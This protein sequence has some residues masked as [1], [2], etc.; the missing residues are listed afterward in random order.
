[1]KIDKLVF[2]PFEVNTY[3]ISGDSGDC[4]IIDCA[5]FDKKESDTL[6]SF[7]RDNN[8]NP[9]MLLNTHC[10][11]DHVFGS[12]FAL[13]RYN[14]KP[15]YHEQEEITLKI[16]NESATLFGWK[17]SAPPQPMRNIADNEIIEFD[18]VRLKAL[19]VPGHS[20]GSLA[21]YNEKEGCVFT[22]DALFAGSIGRTDLIGGN[23]DT[24]VE[25]I[26]KRLLTLPA[27]T[28]AY[29]G[30]GDCTDIETE[31]TSNPWLKPI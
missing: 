2:S 16:F 8:L 28:I 25:S 23:L 31:T 6:E 7:I 30:H 9:I 17:L 22:G 21:F 26:K 14:L 12:N 13:E 15:Q 5:C 1:M 24:L 20:L 27:S 29:P 11:L 19:H 10:H 4:A 18:S 3:I